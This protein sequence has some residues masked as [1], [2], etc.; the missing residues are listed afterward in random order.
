MTLNYDSIAAS[1]DRRYLVNDYSGVGDALL[2]FVGRD[3]RG[4]VLEVGCGTGHWL[5]LLARLQERRSRTRGPKSFRG[6]TGASSVSSASTLFTISTTR[7]DSSP[8]RSAS[9]ARRGN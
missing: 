8:R 5:R 9:F 1:Y 7:P 2:A 4:R 3:L 6:A